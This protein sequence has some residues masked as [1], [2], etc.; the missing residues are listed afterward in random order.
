MKIKIVHQ[1][2]SK[3]IK[4]IKIKNQNKIKTKH[5]KIFIIKAI[6]QSESNQIV[7][8]VLIIIRA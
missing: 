2:K 8:I 3:K 1:I 7:A 5:F 4:I 6:I